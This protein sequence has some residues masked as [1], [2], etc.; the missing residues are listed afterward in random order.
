MAQH[1]VLEKQLFTS[2]G[3][4]TV[5]WRSGPLAA[6][7]AA[8]GFPCVV[9]SARGGYDGKG[10]W[11]LRSQADV[12]AAEIGD[13]EIVVEELIELA[14]ECS[15]IVA[16][17]VSGDVVT[18]PVIE[19]HH[20]AGM[21]DWSVAPARLEQRVLDQAVAAGRALADGIGSVGV[22]CVEF[23][24]TLDGR[25]LTNEFAPRPHNSAH[26]TIEANVTNQL[27][28]QLRAVCGLALGDPSAR[29]AAAMVQVGGDL[30]SGGEPNWN[31]ALSEPGIH[32]HLY[33]KTEPRS[34]RKMGHLTALAPTPD[35]AL[36]AALAARS[37]LR[38]SARTAVSP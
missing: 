14:A 25:L 11:V 12:I 4:P 17:G 28:Q 23:L 26:H 1:R 7:V 19:N 13:R 32:L 38:P 16:R 37:A 21:L 35:L 29:S 10:Q 22:L 34:G 3:L 20:V 9:K 30:W 6:A 31:A 24:G 8:V 18:F 33:G 15:V 27:E 2:L 36:Q 5:R